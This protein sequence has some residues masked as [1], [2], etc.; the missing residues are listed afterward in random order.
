MGSSPAKRAT[1]GR[2]AQL[3]RAPALH[4]GGQRFK[5]STAHHSFNT[6]RLS[7]RHRQAGK[8]SCGFTG[9]LFRFRKGINTSVPRKDIQVACQVFAERSDTQ[10]GFG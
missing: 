5:S 10:A 2:L 1:L 9:S 3:V 7:F 8:A 4:A 6:V